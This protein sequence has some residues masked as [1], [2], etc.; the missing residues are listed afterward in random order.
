M[1]FKE[2]IQKSKDGSKKVIRW[3][4]TVNK[5]L[6]ENKKQVIGFGIDITE[7]MKL[8]EQLFESQKMESIGTLAAGMAYADNPNHEAWMPSFQETTDRYNQFFDLLSNTPDLDV[9][10]EI[11]LL[12]EDLQAIFDAAE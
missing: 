6:G 10:A 11:A 5:Y 12:V 8:E 4:W 7:T 3:S 1:F 2:N 9:D